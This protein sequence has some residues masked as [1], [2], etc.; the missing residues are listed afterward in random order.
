LSNRFRDYRFWVAL[1]LVV[2]TA[3]LMYAVY[4]RLLVLRFEV[5]GESAHHVLSWAG[6][7]FIAIYTPI[8]YW[9]KRSYPNRYRTLL[10]VH[11]FGNLTAVMALSLHF[12]HQITRPA[13]AYPDLGTGVVLYPAVLLLVLAGF[14]LA[15]GFSKKYDHWRFFHSSLAVTFYMVIVVH[16]LHGLGMI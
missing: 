4:A 12:T 10:G 11:M 5:A 15:F 2:T 3:I 13:T 16:L 9:L 7:L 6:V 14:V 8:Y 1:A